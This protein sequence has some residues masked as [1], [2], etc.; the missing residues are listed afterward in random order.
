MNTPQRQSLSNRRKLRLELRALAEHGTH[1]VV[2]DF[3]VEAIAGDAD[4]GLRQWRDA[5]LLAVSVD[6]EALN[7]R[8]RSG[9]R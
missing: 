3:V 2:D 7:P 4:T 5:R 6:F 9:G 1:C 8:T